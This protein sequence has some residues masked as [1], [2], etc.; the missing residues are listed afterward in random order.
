MASLLARLNP[1]DA[2]VR[3]FSALA[4][5]AIER[6]IGSIIAVL[7]VMLAAAPGAWWLKL[8]TDGHALIAENAPE[9]LRDKV[10]RAKFGIQDQIVILIHANGSNGIFNPDTLQLV[11]DLT[12][13]CAKLPGVNPA[14]LMSLATE[15]S[16]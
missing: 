14:N 13:E 3:F 12:A 16:F 15:P 2:V 6:P 8:R 11:C 9:V 4:R 5:T 7:I 1:H 10:V